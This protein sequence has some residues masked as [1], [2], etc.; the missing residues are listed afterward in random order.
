LSSGG[1]FRSS[2]GVGLSSSNKNPLIGNDFYFKRVVQGA[3]RYRE[4]RMD[5]K[6][7]SILGYLF[8]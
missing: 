8:F 2:Q 6:K 5:K 1:L 3:K 4:T 7:M